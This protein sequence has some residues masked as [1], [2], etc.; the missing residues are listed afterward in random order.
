MEGNKSLPSQN[1]EFA[2]MGRGVVVSASTTKKW[3]RWSL[4]KMREF[5]PAKLIGSSCKCGIQLIF[6]RFVLQMGASRIFGI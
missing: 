2:P 5:I 4:F 6:A 3:L 1:K